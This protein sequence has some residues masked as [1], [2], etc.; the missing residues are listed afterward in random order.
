MSVP[1]PDVFAERARLVEVARAQV[2]PRV[3][4]DHLRWATKSGHPAVMPL[5]LAMRATRLSTWPGE[6][7]LDPFCGSGTTLLAAKLLE[8]RAIGCDISERYC[9]LSANRLSQQ[10]FD[11]GQPAEG[12]RL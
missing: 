9:E 3:D 7:V 8:R 10:V 5:E 1:D 4:D 6:V 12:A 11:F 2:L